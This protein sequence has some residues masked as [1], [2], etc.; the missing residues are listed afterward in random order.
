MG[1]NIYYDKS[2]NELVFR[3]PL[4]FWAVFKP[5]WSSDKFYSNPY[6]WAV[7]NI[8]IAASLIRSLCFVGFA[9]GDD[10]YYAWLSNSILTN[11]YPSLDFGSNYRAGLF[12]PITF[13]FSLFGVNDVSFVLYP[14]LISLI[15]IVVIYLICKELFNRNVGI[16]AAI[17]LAFSPFD[18]IFSTTMTIDIITSF[19]TA[20]TFFFFIK[21]TREEGLRQKIYSALASLALF[22]NYL[23]KIP[24]VAIVCCFVILTI[25]GFKSFKKHAVF[26]LS[27][28]IIFGLSFLADYLLTGG[29]LNY[30]SRELKYGP[31]SMGIGALYAFPNW[32]FG[33]DWDGTR[34]FGYY[35]Y[36]A[37]PALIYAMVERRKSSYPIWVWGLM[38][39]TIMEFMPEK[40]S[41]PYLPIARFS[42][43]THAFLLPSIIITA[44]GIYS[45]WEWK[46]PVFF[47]ALIALIVSSNIE[48]GHK[49]KMWKEPFEDAREASKLLTTLPKKPVYSDNW[50]CDRLAFDFQY[51]RDPRKFELN[52]KAFQLDIIEKRAY[53]NLL[54]IKHGYIVAG[55]SRTHDAWVGSIFCLEDFLPPPNWKLIKEFPKEITSFRKE[56]LK[57]YE[58]LPK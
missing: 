10:P 11:G 4:R 13:F 21:A 19:F 24:T 2:N 28:A 35:F 6:F 31:K 15:S 7:A 26:Y 33:K 5:K 58:V 47:V 27:T 8:L 9:L 41:L 20:L 52:G 17:L 57:I 55:G 30:L 53:T 46:K 16:I 43:Y 36:A 1:L 42:R 50:F 49:R 18:A 25:I 32:M 40:F 3:L 39:F 51:K 12:L 48:T 44:L 45:L 38:I 56:T 34:L 23:I 29:F 22:Y 14:F 37:L 54:S